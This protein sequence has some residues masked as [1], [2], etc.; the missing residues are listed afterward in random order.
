[1]EGI[2]MNQSA[3]S[4]EYKVDFGNGKKGRAEKKPAAQ[5]KQTPTKLPR[6]T[7]LLALAH[8]LQDLLDQG[9]VRDYADIA[10]LS[11]LSRARLTQIM[12]LTL[13]APRIQEE[14]LFATART[15]LNEHAMRIALKTPVWD[16]QVDYIKAILI[17]AILS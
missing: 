9:I 15:P 11:R 5:P 4:V 8:H 10:Q 2:S 16:E 12:N 13:L 7:R 14:V 6:I 1:M 17:K 3:I